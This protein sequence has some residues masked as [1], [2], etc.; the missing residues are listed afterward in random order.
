MRSISDLVQRA[1]TRWV[2]LAALAIFVLFLALVLPRQAGTAAES[3]GDAGSPDTSFLYSPADLYRMAEAYG[4]E[5]RAAYVRARFTFDLVWPLV[6]TFF[7]ATS[8]SW[9]LRRAFGAGSRWLLANLVPLLGALFDYFENIAT[10]IVMLRYPAHTPV[11]DV[12]APIFT[13]S[14]WLLLGVSFVLL[15]VAAVAAVWRR[16]HDRRA[17]PS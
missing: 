14:K 1:S 17:A 3:S 12:L 11:V 4:E 10:S 6:Y 16:L 9:L 15:G 5:G 7:L 13:A 2:T 8:L